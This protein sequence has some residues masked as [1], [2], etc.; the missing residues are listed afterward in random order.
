MEYWEFG[1]MVLLGRVCVGVVAENEWKRLWFSLHGP[2][3]AV[4][5]GLHSPLKTIKM[6]LFFSSAEDFGV[7]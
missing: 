5:C 6:G 4:W 7:R 2:R 1:Q 3:T